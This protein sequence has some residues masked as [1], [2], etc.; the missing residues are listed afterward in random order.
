[1]DYM[2][3]KAVLLGF[4]FFLLIFVQLCLAGTVQFHDLY[5][6]TTQD[7][8][9]Q[10]IMR[11][12]EAFR[13]RYNGDQMRIGINHIEKDEVNFFITSFDVYPDENFTLKM[14]EGKSFDINDD[15]I[16][17]FS[18]SLD[19][20]SIAASRE[21][22]LVTFSTIGLISNLEQPI[23]ETDNRTDNNVV[24]DNDTAVKVIN[25]DNLSGGLV[26]IEDLGLVDDRGRPLSAKK[27]TFMVWLIVL[28]FIVLI[29][30]TFYTIYKRKH[31]YLE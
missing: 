20:I 30:L 5:E 18:I 24:V 1:M 29:V 2:G 12:F 6:I 31:H 10:E 22:T 13:F 8:T 16:V 21:R 11:D 14:F 3:K 4:G 23:N 19:N 17:D 28:L 7:I 25:D 27:F 9:R 26:A 15:N